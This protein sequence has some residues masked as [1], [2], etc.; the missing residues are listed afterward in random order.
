MDLTS[1]AKND[2][3]AACAWIDEELFQVCKGVSNSVLIGLR[4]VEKQ[5]TPTAGSRDLPAKCTRRNSLTV[6]PV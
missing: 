6:E 4:T 2:F 3:G 5:V 1:V